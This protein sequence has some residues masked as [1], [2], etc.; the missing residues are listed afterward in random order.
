[1]ENSFWFYIDTY[2]HIAI[3][4]DK[5][6]LYNPYTGKSIEF[7]GKPEL[8]RLIKRIKSPRNLWVV[9]LKERDLNIPE[10][11]RFVDLVKSNFM[12]DLIR[13]SF[14]KGKPIQM[15]PKVK[16][17][18]DVRFLKAGKIRSVGEDVMTHLSKITLTIN[19]ECNHS[20]AICNEAFRQ[21]TCCTSAANGKNQELGIEQIR[22][23][24]NDITK[25]DL[26]ILISGGN[27]FKY[28]ALDQLVKFLNTVQSSKTFYIHYLNLGLNI[29]RIS[30][31]DIRNS[32]LNILVT[33]PLDLKL[34]KAIIEASSLFAGEKRFDFIVQSNEE[35]SSFAKHIEDLQ[36]KSYRYTPFVNRTNIEFFEDNVYIDRNDIEENMP[37][38]RDIY[39]NGT[40]NSNFFGNL[41]ITPDGSVFSNIRDSALGN[42]ET[43]SLYEIMTKELNQGK[44]WLKI[45]RNLMPCKQCVFEMLCPPISN[46]NMAIGKYDLC[47]IRK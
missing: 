23:I 35:F 1:M 45:R 27:I 21:F 14:S 9:R 15:V 31:L 16:I 22:N 6:L 26:K 7:S 32:T 17:Q 8:L 46:Y 38:L 40:I 34:F 11:C 47:H 2:V 30:E 25:R 19:A 41:T 3:K 36:I 4:A 5:I 33:P 18:Q 43:N 10:I 44:N 24:F 12:G 20:C 29:D 28:S 13:S 39:M 37:T 42:V